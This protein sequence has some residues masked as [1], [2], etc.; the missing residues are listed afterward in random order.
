MERAGRRV[1]VN[2][3]SARRRWGS[4]GYFGGSLRVSRTVGRNETRR[5]VD[6]GR[7]GWWVLRS[8]R[9]EEEVRASSSVSRRERATTC[10]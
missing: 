7:M 3:G 1:E 10:G 6:F 4:L 9:H 2:N 5:V 8:R